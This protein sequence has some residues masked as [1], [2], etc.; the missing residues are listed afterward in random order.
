MLQ[1]TNVSK[2]RPSVIKF[3]I[4]WLVL[5]RNS[6]RINGEVAFGVR[7]KRLDTGPHYPTKNFFIELQLE[8]RKEL[9]QSTRLL[10]QPSKSFSSDRLTLPTDSWLTRTICWGQPGFPESTRRRNHRC[11]TAGN[12]VRQTPENI[13]RF[14]NSTY[15]KNI[16]HITHSLTITPNIPLS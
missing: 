7:S 8:I 4:L 16:I 2:L 3:N 14:T 13:T 1:Y 15:H 6:S 9:K 11:Q 12:N 5:L 10:K